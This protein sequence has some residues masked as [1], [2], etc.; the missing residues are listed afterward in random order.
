M[1]G[2]VKN[3]SKAYL[4]QILMFPERL[5]RVLLQRLLNM[6][7]W[8]EASALILLTIL[9]PCISESCIQINCH[10]SLWCLKRFYGGLSGL[11]KTF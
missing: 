9:A 3:F 1:H 6:I 10:T 2:R 5:S 4:T 8:I 7:R 11:H